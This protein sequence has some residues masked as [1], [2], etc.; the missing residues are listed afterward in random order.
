MAQREKSKEINREKIKAAAARI[1]RQEG[2]DKLTM[3]RLAD[4]AEVSLRTPYNLFGSK[5]DV[6]IALLDDA[7]DRFAAVILEDQAR[8]AL[9][10]LLESLDAFHGLYAED[11]AFFREVFYAIMTSDHP[12]SRRTAYDQLIIMTQSLLAQ[13]VERDELDADPKALGEHFAILFM[14]VLGMWGGGFFDLRT[15]LQHVR[16]SWTSQLPLPQDRGLQEE[17]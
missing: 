14:S 8:P 11:E 1:I 16:R 2:M 13:A 7:N 6:L 5:T 3:R 15:C 10:R 12:E 4:A 9:P 17:A